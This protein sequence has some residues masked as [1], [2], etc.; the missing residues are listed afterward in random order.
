MK[1]YIKNFILFILTFL[2]IFAPVLNKLH[3]FIIYTSIVCIIIGLFFK[4]NILNKNTIYFGVFCLILIIY[5]IITSILFDR[6]RII[7][8]ANI[9]LRPIR[10]FLTFLG[11]YYLGFFFRNRGEKFVLANIFGACTLHASI[12]ILQ[13]INPEFREWVYNITKPD[14]RGTYF[15]EIRMAGLQSAAGGAVLS[16]IQSIGIIISPF[17]WRNN[18]LLISLGCVIILGSIFICGR[19]GVLAI[20]LFLPITYFLYFKP[21]IR[22]LFKIFIVTTC[23]LLVLFLLTNAVIN[24]SDNE[25]LVTAIQHTIDGFLKNE[26]YEEVGTTITDVLITM[27]K[28]PDDPLIFLFGKPYYF[29][30]GINESRRLDSD[31]GLIRYWWA[32]GIIGSAIYHSF[33]FYLIVYGINQ[34]KQNKIIANSIIVLS[35]LFLFYQT[36]ELFIFARMGLSIILLLFCYSYQLKK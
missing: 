30:E 22:L 10:I 27:I 32:F 28:I 15:L 14:I 18:K 33:Y 1:I 26:N 7:D 25:F 23:I 19:S 12:M 17:L 11:C 4:T 21:S 20:G 2:I 35:I 3:D 29:L 16:V 13:F 24:N 9:Y 36:K 5:P 6:E 8:N 31:I 34:T